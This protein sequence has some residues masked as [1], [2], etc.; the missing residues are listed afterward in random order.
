M[1][2]R[3]VE[4]AKENSRIHLKIQKYPR[5]G[6]KTQGP[7]KHPPMDWKQ[8]QHPSMDQKLLKKLPCELKP[9]TK[10][11]VK[12]SVMKGLSRRSKVQRQPLKEL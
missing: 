8:Q 11:L 4:S 5:L 7:Q 9:S 3:K 6:K 2:S 1:G 10:S 12:Y